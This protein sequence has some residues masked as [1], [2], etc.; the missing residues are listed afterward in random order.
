[1]T[2]IDNF[3]SRTLGGMR[4]LGALIGNPMGIA[5]GASGAATMSSV[6]ND[7]R[8]SNASRRKKHIGSIN[9]QTQATDAR[10]LRAR[11]VTSSIKALWLA[12]QTM[13]CDNGIPV[14][15]P[16]VPGVPSVIFAVGS[17]TPLTL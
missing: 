1:M 12:P 7:N 17:Q 16:N 3:T 8:V 4:G 15:V 13:D 9:L 11:L 6:S 5:T 14:N 10:V 2:K